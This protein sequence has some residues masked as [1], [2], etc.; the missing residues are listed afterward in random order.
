MSLQERFKTD[1]DFAAQAKQAEQ[2]L[3]DDTEYLEWLEQ[4]ATE[5]L[6]DLIRSQDL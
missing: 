2:I 4:L 6:E 3:T 5:S 1:P